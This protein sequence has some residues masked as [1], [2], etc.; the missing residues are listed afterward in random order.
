MAVTIGNVTD[1]RMFQIGKEF[2]AAG[3][4]IDLELQGSASNSAVA[5]ILSGVSE[6]PR[7][8]IEAAALNFKASTG[9]TV[10]LGDTQ[11]GTVT[12]S[13]H[14]NAGFQANVATD[15]AAALKVVLPGGATGSGLQLSGGAGDRFLILKLNYDAGLTAKGTAALAPAVSA[16][17]GGTVSRTGEWAVVHRFGKVP[18]FTAVEDTVRAWVLPR[19]IDG[20]DRLRPGT[21]IVAEVDGSV[22][23]NL[24]VRAGYDF[25]WLRELPGGAL[26]GDLGL[27]LE[28]ATATLAFS[29][30]GTY[31]LTLARE[32]DAPVL[33]LSLSKAD[34]RGWDFAVSS[35][36][37][38]VLSTK[39]GDLVAAIL[40]IHPAQLAEDLR[41][42]GPEFSG[43]LKL[44]DKLGAQP[45]STLLTLAAEH[46]AAEMKQF[47]TLLGEIWSLQEIHAR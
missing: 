21:W 30:N 11:H 39:P 3:E 45:P 20:V 12:F 47:T 38:A 36:G 28:A 22:A 40:G 17:F 1:R 35:G 5:A 32:T 6:F 25:S 31:V 44:W 18:A 37:S 26:A 2:S 46:T 33:R 9:G 13:A 42:L 14:G 4:N 27:K 43:F 19:Q 15:P 10:P 29:A 7:G 16:T 8:D 34:K 23:V 24:G 41:A